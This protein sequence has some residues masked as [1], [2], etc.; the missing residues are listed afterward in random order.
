MKLSPPYD[1]AIM[2]KS[3]RAFLQRE[4]TALLAIANGHQWFDRLHDDEDVTRVIDGKPYESAGRI[5]VR[6]RGYVG[7]KPDW[8]LSCN[9][10]PL[11]DLV[12]ADPPDGLFD[13]KEAK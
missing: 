6:V 12:V 4:R 7:K 8:G 2:K 11:G 1:V 13:D 10:C 5:V 3:D 9:S